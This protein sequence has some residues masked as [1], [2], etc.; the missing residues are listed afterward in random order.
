MKLDRR[1]WQLAQSARLWLIL[2]IAF[3]LLVGVLIIVQARVLSGIIDRVFLRSASLD[4]E[5]AAM[6]SLLII[7]I[8]RSVLT[9]GSDAAAFQIAAH[10]KAQLRVRLLEHI[11]S[12][13][14]AYVRGE[15][16]GELTNTVMEGI[17]TLEAYFSQYLPQLILAAL[18][19]LA[20]LACVL[21]LDPVSGLVLLVTGPLIPVFM[22]LI[23]KAA[24]AL[25]RRQWKSLSWLNAHFLDVLQG[26]TTLKIFGRSRQQIETIAQVSNRFR[27]AT[28]NVLRVAFLSAFALEMIATIS[29]A[30]VAVEVGLRLL[31]GQLQF[32]QALFV[33]VLAPDFYLP[34]RLLGTRFHAG[35]SGAAA[36]QRIFEIL[37]TTTDGRLPTTANSAS[38][39][40]APSWSTISFNDIHY[41]YNDGQRPALDGVSLTIDRGQHV[42]LIGPTGSGKSTIV[43]LLLRFIEP[44]SGAIEIDRARLS[45][46]DPRGWRAQIA[47]VSQR[48]YLFNESVLDNIRL[49]RPNASRGEV[50]HAAQLAQ[51]AEFICALPQGYE[52]RVGEQGAR[53]SAGQAQ[54]IALA[55]AFLK[56]APIL[57]I[58]E[59]TSNL[60][61]ENEALLQDSIERLM[62]GRTVLTISQRLNTVIH[63]DQI[64]VLANG[65]VAEVGTHKSLLQVNG[66]YRQLVDAD[67]SF[68][69]IDF[70]SPR[71]EESV[72]PID[73]GQPLIIPA[74]DDPQQIPM[75]HPSA[76]RIFWR[77]IK[78]AAPFKWWMALSVLL[79]SL[80][81]G[82][83]IGLMAAAAFI[84]ASAALHPSIADLAVAIVGVRF[85][86]IAR[87]VFRYLE[88]LVS[89]RINLSL[90]A[91]LR[92]WFYR[93][94]EPLAPARLTSY[95]SGDLL[96]RIVGD[97]ETLQNFF[98]RVIAPPAVA[99]I[100]AASMTIY[101]SSFSPMLASA[102]LMLMAVVGIIMPLVVQQISRQ[103]GRQLVALRSE[104]NLQLVDGLQG[105]TD[106]IA[107]GR[108]R[109]QVDRVGALSRNL[110][111]AQT[112]MALIGATQN[113]VG[114]L[115][116]NFTM[117]IVLVMAV[118][119]V[120]A[121]QLSGVFLPVLALAALASFEG[122]LNL[123]PA[124]QY[125]ESNLEAARRL[126]EIVEAEPDSIVRTSDR[127]GSI[128]SDVKLPLE[129]S[130]K[131]LGF[132][133]RPDEPLV[134]DRFS[135]DL[136][137]GRSVA[138]VGSSGAGKSS[139]INVLLRLWDYQQGQIS[140]N[141]RDLR[142]YDPDRVRQLIGVVPQR[143]HLFNASIRDNLLIARPDATEAEMIRSTRQAELHAFIQSLPQGYDT[144]I[145]E[146]GLLL[147]GGER[148]RLAIARALLR[149]APILI[150][151]EATA[152][153]DPVTERSVLSAL[154]SNA[155]D[156]ALLMVTHRLNW[157]EKVDEIIVLSAGRIVERGRHSE[158]LQYNGLYRRMWQPSGLLGQL[159]AIELAADSGPV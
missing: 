91:Q 37:E 45:D 19:P 148:Q 111:R 61:I 119:L 121:G 159:S 43:N 145:G 124:F 139:V 73:R 141:G 129:I 66:V 65:R 60:D 128:D 157:L 144:P 95:R 135:C 34:L 150:L 56:N 18:I 38:T 127:L 53:L 52:T 30:I 39:A 28:L 1:L 154:Q 94:I 152:N 14:P 122:V 80:T 11:V 17:E 147:S 50:I 58:D 81:I 112:R 83:S 132:R 153:L 106:L 23:G 97:V 90:L 5:S 15:R 71:V 101:L 35:M 77:L 33:L 158:L 70:T 114:V 79:G 88:R 86:G 130:I 93:S 72:S 31:S 42:A 137:S 47:Y 10:I 82:S 117:W 99:L 3:G 57:I 49:A 9:W 151:D 123:P 89:H 40:M 41:A 6:I 136:R 140:L 87:G 75:K 116:T 126:F 125:L 143:T 12:L 76:F 98:V 27:D 103:P 133:Y 64:I 63:A 96:S 156:R 24:D 13:G 120:T 78:L 68:D 25:T 69:S 29:T 32:E 142:E 7:I 16:T 108:E 62:Q 59:A 4:R 113:A 84:I 131:N 104:L 100:I 155:A 46:L 115:L 105:L 54:R 138:I 55:R 102:V 134:L 92:V 149:D 26:L 107:F 110:I 21:P 146:Q 51:A 118:P 22:M 36:A 2:T 109:D 44:Q 20:V 67:R 8:A 74:G 48:P 85:F